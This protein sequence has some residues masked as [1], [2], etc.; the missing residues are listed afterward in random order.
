MRRNKENTVMNGRLFQSSQFQKLKEPNN[1]TDSN[2]SQLSAAPSRRN[3]SMGNIFKRLDESLT[4]SERQRESHDN[5]LNLS[6]DHEVL[7]KKNSKPIINPAGHVPR[8]S[9]ATLFDP[10]KQSSTQSRTFKLLQE[11]LDNGK[12][13]F[14]IQ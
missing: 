4:R 5:L 8:R 7:E 1:G 12:R 9:V 11:T 6:R 10:N 2:S 14:Q 3:R 13:L